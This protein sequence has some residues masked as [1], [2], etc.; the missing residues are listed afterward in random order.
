MGDEELEY[1]RGCELA[2]RVTDHELRVIVKYVC[3]KAVSCLCSMCVQ[4]L[5][6]LFRM[7]ENAINMHNSCSLVSLPS[8]YVC[9]KTVSCLD[10]VCDCDACKPA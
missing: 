2:V 4:R 10:N 3:A 6:K 1:A 8:R 9:V 7:H 5:S